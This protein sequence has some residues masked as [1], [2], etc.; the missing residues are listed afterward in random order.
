LTLSPCAE[1]NFILNY[2]KHGGTV[3]RPNGNCPKAQC[4]NFVYSV[5][6]RGKVL[7]TV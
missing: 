6:F 5:D 4:T 2:A 1:G 3:N 7:S